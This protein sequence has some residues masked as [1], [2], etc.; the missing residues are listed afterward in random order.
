MID[1]VRVHARANH[2]G[3]IVLWMALCGR[4]MKDPPLL[5]PGMSVGWVNYKCDQSGLKLQV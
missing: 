3:L 1:H 5:I 2:A 4:R